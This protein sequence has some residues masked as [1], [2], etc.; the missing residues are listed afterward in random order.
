MKPILTDRDRMEVA[1]R[2]QSTLTP[3]EQACAE[4]LA[5][6]MRPSLLAVAGAGDGSKAKA[7]NRRRHLKR[8][9]QRRAIIIKHGVQEHFLAE[10]HRAADTHRTELTRIE[11]EIIRLTAALPR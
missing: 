10:L 3:L 6:A 4:I 2:N 7:Q 1:T 5:L 8:A 9:H 11:R